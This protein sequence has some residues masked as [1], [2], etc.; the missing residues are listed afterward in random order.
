MLDPWSR[1]GWMNTSGSTRSSPSHRSL[2]C[3]QP[4]LA[5]QVMCIRQALLLARAW[6]LLKTFSVV[7]LKKWTEISQRSNKN[8]SSLPTKL[9]LKE[10]HQRLAL[11][12]IFHRTSHM[13]SM[14]FSLVLWTFSPTTVT[15]SD[16]KEIPPKVGLLPCDSTL[17]LMM[18]SSKLD[19]SA[20]RALMIFRI[21]STM[22]LS[23]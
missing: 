15:P 16:A 13:S 21:W 19:H 17:E 9:L 11:M 6:W 4:Q 2:L 18:L 1:G 8:R 5:W 14:E 12:V 7:L 3:K 20:G 10:F 22:F 23:C